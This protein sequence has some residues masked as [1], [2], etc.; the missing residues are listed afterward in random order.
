MLPPVSG[1]PAAIY[2]DVLNDG[3]TDMVIRAVSVEGADS[4]VIH[5]MGTWSGE[6]VM[7]DVFQLAVPAGASTKLI[8][9]EMHVMAE[10]LPD[11]LKPG[12]S[13]EVTLTFAG[14]DKYSFPTEVRAAGDD[15]DAPDGDGDASDSQ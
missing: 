9:G 8:P 11:T 5:K 7:N 3:T 6:E 15:R 14:G 12:D 13:I 1:N 4:A 10:G 2:F